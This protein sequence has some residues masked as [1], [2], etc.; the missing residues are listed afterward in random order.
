[1]ADTRLLKSKIEPYV[2][3][4]LAEKFGKPFHSEFLPLSSAKDRS[5]KHEFDA[6]SN[7]FGVETHGDKRGRRP[8]FPRF[9]VVRSTGA[10]AERENGAFGSYI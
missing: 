3:T 7:T 8:E 1:M 2:R 4:W 5:A 6:V 9:T 10:N